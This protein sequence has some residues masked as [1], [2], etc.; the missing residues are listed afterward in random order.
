MYSEK[1]V[2]VLSNFDIPA[3]DMNIVRGEVFAPHIR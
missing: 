2:K 1:L 3:V